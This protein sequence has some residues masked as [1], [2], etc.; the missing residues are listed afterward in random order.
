MIQKT[1]F[2]HLFY[3]LKSKIFND[4][5]FSL[6]TRLYETPCAVEKQPV[7]D[8]FRAKKFICVLSVACL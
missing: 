2:Y 8:V 3:Y 5:S 1:K 6:R 4:F 7:T